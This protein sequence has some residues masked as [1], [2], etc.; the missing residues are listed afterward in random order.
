MSIHK[1]VFAFFVFSLLAIF[2]S[3]DDDN[4]EEVPT[5]AYVCATCADVPDALPA[6]DNLSAGIYK[7]V[8]IGSSGTIVFDVANDGSTVTALLQLDGDTI[9][10]TS[11]I[12]WVPGNAYLAPFTGLYNGV[13]VSITFTVGANGENPS[14]VTSDIPG[15]PTAE[16]TI[17]KET[18]TSLIT[19][20]EGTY[21]T[22]E[23]EDGTFNVIISIDAAV[24]TASGRENGATSSGDPIFGTLV[25]GNTLVETS[26]VTFA[27]LTG[28]VIS[29]SFLDSGNRTVTIVGERTL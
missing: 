16:F 1:P 8:F 5:P 25:N 11:A 24:W 4:D 21:H 17:V 15:H 14:V 20:Y 19:C 22:T 26:G 6:N 12:S 29:G 9:H 27:T 10:L 28:D 18:S 7:G 13:A 23:P 3:C 2:T